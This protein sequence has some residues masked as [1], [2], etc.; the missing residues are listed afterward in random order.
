M[1]ARHGLGV[2]AELEAGLEQQPRRGFIHQH[3]NRLDGLAARLQAKA[4]LA[5]LDEDRQA[6][7]A[8][9]LFD[10]GDP[11]AVLHSEE[12][13]DLHLVDDDE[14]LGAAQHIRGNGTGG[15]KHGALEDRLAGLQ[16]G[17]VIGALEFG[18]TGGGGQREHGGKKQE[19]FHGRMDAR[20]AVKFPGV[21]LVWKSIYATDGEE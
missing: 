8:A 1:R 14:A 20:R 16:A 3:V 5:G 6:P 10:H 12:E 17:D 18:G 7:L 21:G 19:S 9:G 13:A 4:E 11:P 2:Q 15:I